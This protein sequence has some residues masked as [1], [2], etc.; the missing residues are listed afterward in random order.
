MSAKEEE[1]E[2]EKKKE[3]QT[4]LHSHESAAGCSRKGCGTQK[5]CGCGVAATGL[6]LMESDHQSIHWAV[7]FVGDKPMVLSKPKGV[8]L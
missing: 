7:A 2:E 5:E 4:Q 1:E 8:T 6:T 3:H